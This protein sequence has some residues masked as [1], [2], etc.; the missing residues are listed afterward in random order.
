MKTLF[1]GNHTCGLI[2][3]KALMDIT[4]V[5]GVV[6]HPKDPEDGVCYESVYSFALQSNLD[7]IRGTGKDVAVREF[8]KAKKPDLIWITDY[9]YLLPEEL[10]PLTPLGIINLHPSLLPQYRGRA[11][12]NWAILNGEEYLGLTAHFVDSGMDTGDIIMQKTIHL[13][14]EEDV[15]DALIKLYPLYDSVSR[16]VIATILSGDVVSHPQDHSK[17][18]T[19]RSRR[20]QDGKIDWSKSAMEINNLIRAVAPPYPGAFTYFSDERI[21]ILKAVQVNTKSHSVPG[22]ITSSSENGLVVS[23][24]DDS[25]LLNQI[26]CSISISKQLKPGLRFL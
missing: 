26:Q 8:I 4:N 5:V 17:S 9:R 15:S 16:D 22:T 7:S 13:S 2:A 24:G 1:M 18:S 19:Y 6:A 14:S 11:P 12:I 20:P 21:L 23:C 3:L 25:L 10:L